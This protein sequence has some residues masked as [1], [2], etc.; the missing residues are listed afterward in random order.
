MIRN[1]KNKLKNTIHLLK[2]YINSR[3]INFYNF[4]IENNIDDYWLYRFVKSRKI[5]KKISFF[6]VFGKRFI[7]DYSF[8]VG[9]KVF[10]T[11]ENLT[12]TNIFFLGYAPKYK[13]HCLNSVDLSLGFDYI[14]HPKYMR[15]PL[16][17]KYLTNGTEQSINDIE[18]KI[19]NIN[20]PR[21]RLSKGRNYFA[22][23]ISRHD[24]GGTRMKLINLLNPISK[25][26]CAG[27]FMN[28]TNDLKEKFND[29]KLEFL[30]QFKFNICPENSRANGYITEKIFEAIIC[31]CIPIYY[32]GRDTPNTN[33]AKQSIEPEILN[34]EAFI[35]YNGNNEEEVFAKVKELW[36]NQSAYEEFCKIPPF[37]ENAAKVIWSKLQEL[38]DRLKK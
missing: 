16:W 15:F 26:T 34:P 7:V 25:V 17:I 36:E 4:W 33:E 38:E 5:N 18:E 3:Q 37:K 14:D 11:G 35:F 13:N 22:S 24:E 9:K 23:L 10:F 31:G 12:E 27:A 19:N 29:N 8:G 32:G 21:H 28:N 30:K 2:I 6:S 1:I 20:N